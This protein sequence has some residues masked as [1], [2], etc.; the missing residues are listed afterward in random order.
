MIALHLMFY[1]VSSSSERNHKRKYLFYLGIKQTGMEAIEGLHFL[2]PFGPPGT[3]KRK[4]GEKMQPFNRFH[5]HPGIFVVGA[6]KLRLELRCALTA[7]IKYI[8]YSD[9]W[10]KYR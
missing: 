4:G 3:A 1:H 8:Y 2:V 9:R 6:Q 5:S 7:Q 10:S